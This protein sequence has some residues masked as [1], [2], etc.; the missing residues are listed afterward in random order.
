MG[1]W[2]WWPHTI[3]EL[4]PNHLPFSSFR[5]LPNLHSS[6][7]LRVLSYPLSEVLF[8]RSLLKSGEKDS[9]AAAG[10]SF[11]RGRYR[12][13]GSSLHEWASLLQ[14]HS[15]LPWPP[16]FTK[17]LYFVRSKGAQERKGRDQPF[18]PP[19]VLYIAIQAFLNPLL[20][21]WLQSSGRERSRLVKGEQ[22]VWFISVHYFL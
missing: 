1:A 16:L 18:F 21:S 14:L 11:L 10:L 5:S 12:G 9:A 20:M 2:W 15:A 17:A 8:I 13:A 3:S 7:S 4:T 6:L 22:K 19:F